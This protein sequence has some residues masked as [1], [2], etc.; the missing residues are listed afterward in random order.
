MIRRLRREAYLVAGLVALL[1]LS[2]CAGWWDQESDRVRRA[3]IAYELAKS[4]SLVD[5]VVVRLSP[6]EFRADFAGAS[7]MVW[8][9]SN[10]LERRYR[11]AE[12]FATR[13]PGRSY[14]FVQEIRYDGSHTRALVR[15]VLYQGSDAPITKDLELLKSNAGWQVE[16]ERI[17]D[18]P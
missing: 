18:V 9:V 15:T 16:S 11:E 3:A 7:R 13:D 8:L 5:D 2:S 17:V 12:Y 14:L 10:P 1:A 4:G 6:G